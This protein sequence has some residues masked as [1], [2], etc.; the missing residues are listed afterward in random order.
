MEDR[1]VEDIEEYDLVEFNNEIL[2]ITDVYKTYGESVEFISTNENGKE[3]KF[4]SNWGE[5]LKILV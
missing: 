1:L 4:S 3:F 5:S 2:L